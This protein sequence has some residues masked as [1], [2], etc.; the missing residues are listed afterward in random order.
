[1]AYAFFTQL[2]NSSAEVRVPPLEQGFVR[3][4]EQ[5]TADGAEMPLSS[6]SYVDI[7]VENGFVV[8]NDENF[9]V[10]KIFSKAKGLQSRNDFLIFNRNG[11]RTEAFIVELK[12]RTYKTS[13]VKNQLLT[14]TALLAYCKRLGIDRHKDCSRFSALD[15]YAVILTSTVTKRR[16]SALSEDLTMKRFAEK[17]G[18]GS[19]AVCVNGH[20]VTLEDLRVH[21]IAVSLEGDAVNDFDCI[22]PYP[23]TDDSLG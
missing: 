9:R 23:G 2:F 11:S 4:K 1:M 6:E 14:G 21:A 12:S 18:V 5:A 17:C 8:R 22:P 13:S 20:C 10:K 3:L 15:V 16:R 19:G 7:K